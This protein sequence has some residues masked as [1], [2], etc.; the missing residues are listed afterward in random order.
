MTLEMMQRRRRWKEE[1]EQQTKGTKE[2]NLL[3]SID[4]EKEIEL[5]KIEQPRLRD[6]KLDLEKPGEPDKIEKQLKEE[7]IE[8]GREEGEVEELEDLLQRKVE[9]GI[10]MGCVHVPCLCELVELERKIMEIRKEDPIP[11][12][13]VGNF[14]EIVCREEE[15][16]E[17]SKEDW[18]EE[19]EEDQVEEAE[20][21]LLA[22][23][24]PPDKEEEHQVGNNIDP[25]NEFRKEN[26]SKIA[27]EEIL[28][29]K[30]EAKEGNKEDWTEEMEGD[31]VKEAEELPPAPT[32]L[33]DKEGR[34]QVGHNLDLEKEFR[35]EEKKSLLEKMKEKMTNTEMI[36]RKKLKPASPAL[37]ERKKRAVAEE[38]EKVK[39]SMLEEWLRKGG[40]EEE[41]RVE[42]GKVLDRKKG[43]VV[44]KIKNE[45]DNKGLKT[46]TKNS[47]KNDFRAALRKFSEVGKEEDHFKKWKEERLAK[48]RKAE[49]DSQESPSAQRGR[50]KGSNIKLKLGDQSIKNY[51]NVTC[52][53][54]GEGEIDYGP[55][56]QGG[57]GGVVSG[58]GEILPQLLGKQRAGTGH[59]RNLPDS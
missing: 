8:L 18:T 32:I 11:E 1:K 56:G 23:T 10:C 5:A 14:R 40:K 50:K 57:S 39:K 48:K 4:D 12:D 29:K 26:G 6:P 49:G 24:I 37:R 19:V 52:S 34:N 33:P 55:G 46:E 2:G 54:R 43:M 30:E 38:G 41:P 36:G 58:G 42:E 47:D 31:Q 17:G 20:E 15:I 51:F 59:Q 7:G 3:V 28:Y 16:K 9:G 13:K 44:E 27:E 53:N 45:L 35:K 21:L 22:P 25:E